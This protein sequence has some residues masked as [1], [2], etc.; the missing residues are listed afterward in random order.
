MKRILIEHSKC[1]LCGGC[2]AVC[3]PTALSM[4][5]DKLFY[6]HERCV[7][8]MNCVKVCPMGAIKLGEKDEDKN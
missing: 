2:V 5:N 1:K 4:K 6:S 8:C 3:Q 7:F